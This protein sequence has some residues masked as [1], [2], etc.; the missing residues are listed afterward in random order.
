LFRR[1]TP[2]TP[3]RQA[4]LLNA[5]LTRIEEDLIAGAV[6]V[7]EAGRIRTRSLPIGS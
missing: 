6:A 4:A 5:N 2:R 1:G 3:E 7:F